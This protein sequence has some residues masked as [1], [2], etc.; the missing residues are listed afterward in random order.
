MQ[1]KMV[2]GHIKPVG[3]LRIARTQSVPVTIVTHLTPACTWRERRVRDTVLLP[4]ELLTEIT[5][6]SMHGNKLQYNR[7]VY[8]SRFPPLLLHCAALSC[9]SMCCQCP[10]FA[11]QC[12]QL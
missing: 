12:Y 11:L 8:I 4:E 9:L 10:L 3:L 2:V 1:P 7:F 5:L 6:S